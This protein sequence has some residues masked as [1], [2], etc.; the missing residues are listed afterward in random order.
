MIMIRE[1]VGKPNAILHSDGLKLYSFLIEELNKEPKKKIAVSFKGLVHC[2]TSFLNASIGK[3]ILNHPSLFD[4][5]VFVDTENGM[6]DEK[7]QLVINNA[8]TVK[9]RQNHD[10]SVREYFEN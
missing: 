1:I 8:R 2:T 10:E 6:L 7:I 4:K 5:L 3:L 9:S